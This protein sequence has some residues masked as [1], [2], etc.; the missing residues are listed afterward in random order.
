VFFIASAR[1]L[2]IQ[3]P[4]VIILHTSPESAW[5]VR[6]VQPQVNLLERDERHVYGQSRDAI[7]TGL[8]SGAPV[9]GRHVLRGSTRLVRRPAPS[10]ITR[11][12]HG[13][14]V[15]V[16]EK[17][18]KCCGGSVRIHWWFLSRSVFYDA[19][20]MRKLYLLIAGLILLAGKQESI[21]SS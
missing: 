17:T 10:R 19:A 20:T 9:I 13:C 4:I 2:I 1:L 15:T 8:L 5:R 11:R 16:G 6:R 7:C 12:R 3:F 21:L 18:A 14:S